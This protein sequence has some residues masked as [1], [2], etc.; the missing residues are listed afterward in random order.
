MHW[1]QHPNPN[2]EEQITP[3]QTEQIRNRL[4]EDMAKFFGSGG[5]VQQ[6]DPETTGDHY[7][8]WRSKSIK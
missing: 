4:E 5:K 2:H 6:L 7:G 1:N 8:Q 3:K